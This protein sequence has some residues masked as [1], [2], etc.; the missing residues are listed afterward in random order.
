[1]NRVLSGGKLDVLLGSRSSRQGGRDEQGVSHKA[2]LP[3]VI[4]M[5]A[6]TRWLGFQSCHEAKLQHPSLLSGAGKE[7]ESQLKGSRLLLT[8]Q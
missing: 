6:V 7:P 8:V 4:W 1:M 5:E 2:A 3:V